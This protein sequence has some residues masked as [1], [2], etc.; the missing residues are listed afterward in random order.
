[1]HRD[2][3]RPGRTKRHRIQQRPV[4]HRV[5][6]VAHVLGHDI[7]MGHAPR[8]QMIAREGDR[9]G[10]RAVRHQPVDGAGQF[11]AFA[12]AQSVRVVF[13]FCYAKV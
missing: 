1:M 8:I 12:V 5:R 7:G 2:Q 4:G 11:G 10:Q 6:S 13:L 3:I 9:T